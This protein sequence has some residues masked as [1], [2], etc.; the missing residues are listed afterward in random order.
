MP[1][2]RTA[3][4]RLRRVPVKLGART[5][6]FYRPVFRLGPFRLMRGADGSLFWRWK[7]G[8][9]HRLTPASAPSP[10]SPPYREQPANGSE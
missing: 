9:H 6:L 5:L 1:T 3:P 10:E 4:R 7:Q 2:Q 8:R